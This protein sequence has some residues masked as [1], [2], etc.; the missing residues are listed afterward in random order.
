VL[1][2]VNSGNRLRGGV[3]ENDIVVKALAGLPQAG[4]AAQVRGVEGFKNNW[5][6]NW[7]VAKL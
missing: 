6:K 1:P 2:G 3:D 4:V 5:K 7:V